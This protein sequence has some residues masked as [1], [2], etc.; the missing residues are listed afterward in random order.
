MKINNGH[1][2]N[3]A[4]LYQK[5]HK[6]IE[7]ANKKLELGEITSK[8]SKADEVI[9]SKEAKELAKTSQIG[10]PQQEEKLASLK[11]QIEAGTYQPKTEDIAESIIKHFFGAR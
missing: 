4:Q 3:A 9:I 7:K 1:I 6:A 5:Q 10:Q 2:N 8:G 11:A